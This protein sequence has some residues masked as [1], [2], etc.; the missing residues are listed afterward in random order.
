MKYRDAWLAFGKIRYPSV[1]ESAWVKLLS[2]DRVLVL[3]GKCCSA[4]PDSSENGA[5]A[6]RPLP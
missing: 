6:P 2:D 1:S 5:I 3:Q 4:D